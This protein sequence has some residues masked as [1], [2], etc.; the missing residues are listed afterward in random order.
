MCVGYNDIVSE[1][2]TAHAK[3]TEAD[4]QQLLDD[5]IRQ[6]D[7]NLERI[8]ARHE[9]QDRERKMFYSGCVIFTAGAMLTRFFLK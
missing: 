1:M 8:R 6:D 7:E 3:Y 2:P 9:R 5:F 4:M